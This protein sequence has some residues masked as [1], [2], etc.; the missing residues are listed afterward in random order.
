MYKYIII[1]LLCLLLISFLFYIYY[2]RFKE[3]FDNTYTPTGQD[4][5]TSFA[6]EK[7][8]ILR[9]QQSLQDGYAEALQTEFLDGLRIT[10]FKPKNSKKSMNSN[11]EYCFLFNDK[12]N[13]Y[14]D[15]AMNSPINVDPCTKQNPLFASDFIKS[16]YSDTSPT[17]MFTFD[18]R[19]CVLEID[20]TKVNDAALSTFWGNVASNDCSINT[21]S[22]R[23]ELSDCKLN[24]QNL[25]QNY[26]TQSNAIWATNNSLL[27][28]LSGLT[29]ENNTA[30][31]GI[32]TN[33]NLYDT[34]LYNNAYDQ[35]ILVETNNL[36][37]AYNTY[38][39]KI[40]NYTNQL[41]NA[42]GNPNTGFVKQIND[43]Y[44]KNITTSNSCFKNLQNLQKS[45][46]SFKATISDDEYIGNVQRQVF[47]Q[48]DTELIGLQSSCNVWYDSNVANSNIVY[49]QLHPAYATAQQ[50]YASI[51]SS[52]AMCQTELSPYMNSNYPELIPACQSNLAYLM[53]ECNALYEGMGYYKG[54]QSTTQESLDTCQHWRDTYQK[55]YDDALK[56]KNT[57]YSQMY[58]NVYTYGTCKAGIIGCLQD[59]KVAQRKISSLSN[60]ANV[61][62]Y[63]INTLDSDLSQCRP[64]SDTSFNRLQ[65]VQYGMA[66]QTMNANTTNNQ[67]ACDSGAAVATL[68][69]QYQGLQAQIQI[70]KKRLSLNQTIPPDCGALANTCGKIT[71]DQCPTPPTSIQIVTPSISTPIPPI[72]QTPPVVAVE[73]APP[74]PAPPK[75]CVINGTSYRTST[76]VPN[77]NATGVS[78]QS[79]N[80]ASCQLTVQN[81]SDTCVLPKG[82][83]NDTARNLCTTGG[84]DNNQYTPS[85]GF[86]NQN[87]SD[88]AYTSFNINVT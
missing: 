59:L 45:V 38:A 84:N 11:N 6:I 51:A 72:P 33:T 30:L 22:L 75:T 9:S 37:T 1:I 4:V 74:A 5:V 15:L 26:I 73:E 23:N 86:Q 48:Y 50:N 42:Y 70:E 85:M 21:Q 62:Q 2:F 56:T 44:S 53:T 12:P 35:S 49:D 61:Q 68:N 16:V 40:T 17:D 31:Q 34:C 63:T 10:K 76:Y 64:Q 66:V 81:G 67:S 14:F 36:K 52:Y 77:Q 55:N 39:D 7:C 18:L 28:T 20:P 88:D 41:S 87:L 25:E 60:I 19:K 27:H 65:D 83:W 57:C 78:M 13:N 71:L 3:H 54:L 8:D 58:N 82:L 47:S 46:N 79:Q 32:G 43:I 29:S 80:G 69:A 24:M